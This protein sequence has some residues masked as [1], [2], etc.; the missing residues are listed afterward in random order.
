MTLERARLFGNDLRLGRID[1]GADLLPD[2]AG[3]LDLAIGND[4]IVQALTLRLL[5]RQGELARLGWPD[6]GSRLHELI[7]EPNLRRTHLRAM[8]Y[9]R[10]SVEEDPRVAEVSRI[11]AF[12]PPGGRDVVRLDV[13]VR[14]I[15]RPNPLN[16]VFDLDLEAR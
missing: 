10:A 8:A 1:V 13:D 7:G 2:A 3:D 15:D 16:L 5:V 11:Q 12:V 6:Y 4:N 14:L 9:A